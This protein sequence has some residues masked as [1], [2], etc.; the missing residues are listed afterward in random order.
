MDYYIDCGYATMNKYGEELCGDRVQIVTTGDWKTLVLADGMGSSVRA[1]IL[2]T[3]TS[4]IL[5]TMIANGAGIDECVEIITETL[6]VNRDVGLNYCTFTVI[7]THKSGAGV[8]FEFDNPQAIFYHAGECR[9]LERTRREIAGETVYRSQFQLEHGDYILTM[10]DGVI[11]AGPDETMN[12]NWQRPQVKQFLNS[13]SRAS[14]SACVVSAVLGGAC[15]ALYADRPRDDTTVATVKA[16]RPCHVAVMIG[17][18]LDRDNTDNHIRHFLDFKGCHIVCGGTTA[19]LVAACMGRELRVTT[20]T[21][22]P[23]VPPVSL[24]DGVDL[25]TEGALTVAKVARLSDEYLD[26]YALEGRKYNKNNGASK[27]ASILFE[28]ASDITFFIGNSVNE[29]HFGTVADS[30]MKT[31]AIQHLCRN[32]RTMGK[33]VR[34]IYH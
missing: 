10:S 19:E 1:N 9:D 34:E 29:A 26:P 16:F 21:D 4:K 14:M 3:M 11:F 17:P 23:E 20:V 28:E 12:F 33:E 13:R 8:I 7:R 2:S 27:M 32:L 15:M 6:P 18:P 24:I 25:V 31:K 22:D 5:S 30:Q